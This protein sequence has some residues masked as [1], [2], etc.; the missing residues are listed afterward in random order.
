MELSQIRELVESEFK[1]DISQV[2]RIREVVYVRN[3]YY[4]LARDYT[5]FGYSDI[6]KEINKNHAT[7]IHG[8]KTMEEVVL[9][10]DSKFIKA[11]SK[12]SKILNKLT[13]DPKKYLQPDSYYR[14]KY[15]ELM[16]EHRKLINIFRDVDKELKHIKGM[17]VYCE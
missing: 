16:F 10:Y 3:L 5:S 12:I 7:V 4:K 15:K 6:G 17:E 8:V 14:E 9:I 13:N 1:I 2:T 11:Y